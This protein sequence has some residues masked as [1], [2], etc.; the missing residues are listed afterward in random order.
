MA[1]L[2]IL[3]PVLIAAAALSPFEGLAQAPNDVLAK[4]TGHV[5]RVGNLRDDLQ[6]ASEKLPEEL[7]SARAAAFDR[8]MAE[9][10][11][12]IE[13]RKQNTTVGR[14][15][16]STR[17]KIADPPAA[18]V[19]KLYDANR[20]SLSTYS[21]AE[22]RQIVIDYLRQK[23]EQEA[24]SALILELQTKYKATAGKNVNSAE[25][26]PAEVVAT[27]DGKT[28]TAAE[29]DR[30]VEF[31]LYELRADNAERLRDA[32]A[33]MLLQKL[34]SDEA[35]AEKID[36]GALI[37]R[38]IT[39]KMKDY[40][41]EERF[42]LEA[43]FRNRLFQKYKAEILLDLP[44]PP[45][46]NIDTANS[47]AVGPADAKA[48]IVMFSDLQC[49]ACAAAHPIIKSVVAEFPNKARFV[50]RNFPLEGIHK[51]ARNASLA[52]R[53]AFNQGKFFEFA[54]ILY[55]NQNRLDADSLAEYAKQ[56]GLNEKQFDAD[57]R[58]EKTAADIDRDIW[59]GEMLQ[60]SGTPT[61]YVNGIRMRRISAISLR[62][63]IETA[64]S[65]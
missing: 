7:R 11:L 23:P 12:Q 62:N 25:L 54:E 27:I 51:N 38:E 35:A 47:A 60:I 64:L 48:V 65:H 10:V 22:G 49:S 41:D 6:A 43:T 50:V 32:A 17:S 56:L 46:F 30:Y 52:A 44:R 16:A 40:S 37:A 2:Y 36:A 45:V 31:D 13:A 14:L 19:T 5:V 63:A 15:L 39:S 24:V 61:V 29:F 55:K 1:K 4:A 8:M 59:D 28:I 57:F 33:E 34:I 26:K 58:S 53:A 3:I 20:T 9:R 18:E 42:A 21:E